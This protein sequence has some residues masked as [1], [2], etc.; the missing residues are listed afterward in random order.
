MKRALLDIKGVGTK[1]A[2][3]ILDEVLEVIESDKERECA[4]KQKREQS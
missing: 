4:D 1:T 3:N 2:D